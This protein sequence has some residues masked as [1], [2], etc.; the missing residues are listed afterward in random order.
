[1]NLRSN[2]DWTFGVNYDEKVRGVSHITFP[3]LNWPFIKLKGRL[4]HSGLIEVFT[5]SLDKVI[6]HYLI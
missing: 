5:Y 2:F 6:L 4:E 3:S 1:M